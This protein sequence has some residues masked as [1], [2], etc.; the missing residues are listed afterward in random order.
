MGVSQVGPKLWL[1]GSRQTCGVLP[2]AD[3]PPI[4]TPD[5]SRE[6]K[7]LCEEDE[8]GRVQSRQAGEAQA[9]VG[10]GEGMDLQSGAQASAPLP[11]FLPSCQPF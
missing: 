3:L 8:E 2:W 10:V 7:T 11:S 6:L 5:P 1:G 9:G 4:P